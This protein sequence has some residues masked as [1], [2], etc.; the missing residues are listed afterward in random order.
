[1][2]VFYYA[3][4]AIADLFGAGEKA[5]RLLFRRIDRRIARGGKP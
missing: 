1:M 4:I 5:C 3:W 2:D